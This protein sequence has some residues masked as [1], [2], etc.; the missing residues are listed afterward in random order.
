MGGQAA[1]AGHERPGPFYQG[2][3]EALK[4]H[5]KAVFKLNQQQPDGKTLRDHLEAAE[6]STGRRP[7]DLDVPPLPPA[8]ADVWQLFLQLRQRSGG[9]FG[10]QPLDEPRLLA[11]CQLHGQRLTSWEVETIF[12]LDNVW[13]Q[14]ESE[15]K[16]AADRA[17]PH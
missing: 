2:L 16:P 12:G 1:A 14:A 4:D 8:C 13:L 15:S 17:A 9:G 10:P 6:R 11:W 7:A 5:A 3:S